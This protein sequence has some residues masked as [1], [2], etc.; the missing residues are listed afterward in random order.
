MHT[1]PAH[2]AAAVSACSALAGGGV[3]AHLPAPAADRRVLSAEEVEVVRAFARTRSPRVVAGVATALDRILAEEVASD[4]A[5][6]LRHLLRGLEHGPVAEFGGRLTQLEPML[7]AEAL[8]A[9]RAGG[10][11]RLAVTVADAFITWAIDEASA[12]Q[13][14]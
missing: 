13:A 9:Y 7:A 6:V 10:R 4:A 2:V 5:A 8:D 1:N 12:R 11:L 14:A 3:L